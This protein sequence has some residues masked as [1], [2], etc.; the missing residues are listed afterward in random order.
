MHNNEIS[1]LL[2]L[3]YFCVHD[4]PNIFKKYEYLIIAT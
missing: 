2:V 3:I 4:F 1:V